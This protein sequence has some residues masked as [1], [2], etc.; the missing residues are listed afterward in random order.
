MSGAKPDQSA[1][2][3][4]SAEPARIKPFELTVRHAASLR[5][6]LLARQGQMLGCDHTA[7]TIANLR[8]LAGQVD[9]LAMHLKCWNIEAAVMCLRSIE[10]RGFSDAA[11]VLK[12]A[13]DGIASRQVFIIRATRDLAALRQAFEQEVAFYKQL[14]PHTGIVQFSV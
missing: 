11:R 9:Q 7:K 6:L 4:E 12:G 10:A 1:Q 14:A 3:V 8:D 2:A 13:D 5:S